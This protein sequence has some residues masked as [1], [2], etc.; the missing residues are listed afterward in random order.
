VRIAIVNDLRLAIEALRRVV[1]SV[2]G[3]EVAWIA[4][5]GAEAVDKCAKDLPDL[6]LMDLIM[7]VMD[8]VES[9]RQ[10]MMCSPCPILVVTATVSGNAAKV[11]DAMGHGA[12]DAVCTPVL[13]TSGSVEGGDALLGKIATIAKLGTKRR[14]PPTMR[15]PIRPA[16]GTPLPPLVAIGAS[17]GGPKALAD[18]L[19]ALPAEIAAAIVIIQH[20]DALFAPGL[21]EWLASQTA[22]MV[23][24]ARDGDSPH[25]GVVLLA[26]GDDHL[27]MTTAR[28]LHHTPHPIDYPYRP[29]VDVFFETAATS[30]PRKGLGI[31]L[32]GMG[33]DGGQGLLALHNAGWQTIAQDRATSVVYG[34]PK[35]AAELD[36]A[37]EILALPDIAP[38]I[39]RFVERAARADGGWAGDAVVPRNGK[40]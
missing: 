26:G 21:V 22:L 8:G 5:N 15:I 2:P 40:Q 35:A 25:P 28:T 34:M 6:I 20:V 36:A 16:L 18:I 14:S 13:G 7:P 3:Y 23:R 11:F 29:S 24:S 27:T 39:V 10:I 19:G 4:I 17:T 31:L 30:W 38:A 37:D 32:T 1:V 33:R 9:T 12:L